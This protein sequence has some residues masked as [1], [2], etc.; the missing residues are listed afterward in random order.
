MGMLCFLSHT[1]WYDLVIWLNPG[2]RHRGGERTAF[3]FRATSSP[4][5]VRAQYDY[6]G[7]Q[8]LCLL[9]QSQS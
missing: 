5:R 1:P 7:P 4:V 2:V 3:L 8:D 6:A 9:T